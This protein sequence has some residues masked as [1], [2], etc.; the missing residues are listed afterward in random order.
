MTVLIGG[1]GAMG[2]MISWSVM[3]SYTSVVSFHTIDH[4]QD[5]TIFFGVRVLNCSSF[6]SKT[7]K[8]LMNLMA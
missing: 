7:Y 5:R 1:G 3:Q 8:I 6:R 4:G 2:T